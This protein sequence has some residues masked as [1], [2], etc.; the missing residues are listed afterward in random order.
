MNSSISRRRLLGCGAACVAASFMGALPL[1]A[2]PN[3]R[4]GSRWKTANRLLSPFTQVDGM[5][6]L[7]GE[8]T[9]EAWDLAEERVRW[10]QPLQNRAAFRP[11]VAGSAVI[12]GGRGHL[13]AWNRGGGESLWE[14]RP[15]GELGVPLIHNDRVHLGERH[16]LIT[17]DA[18]SGRRL[19]SF[20]TDR[21]AR[22]AY[23]PIGYRDRLLLGSGDGRL[24]AFSASDGEL[25]WRVDR[26]ADWQYLRQLAVHDSLLIAGG[27]HD[28][29]FAISLDDGSIIWRFYAGNFVNSQLVVDRKV[30]FWSPTGWI[31]ALDADTGALLWRHRTVD[32]R[33]RDRPQN[34][35]SVMAELVAHDGRLYILAM[36]HVLHVL[37]LDSGRELATHRLSLAVRP[38]VCIDPAGALY[39]GSS[40]GEIVKLT[41]T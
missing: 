22:I 36:D 13:A 16:R 32:Y 29:I 33:E 6:Y 34:W 17:L 27:Y 21:S 40:D 41:L 20:D 5:L 12:T 35:A 28:E 19:W 24:Y 8:A 15:T 3:Y 25:L 37:D 30:C 38:F 10:R 1:F 7:N 23:A 2:G 11:R 39:L 26:E 18:A 14:Y 9:V 31:Y 4:L